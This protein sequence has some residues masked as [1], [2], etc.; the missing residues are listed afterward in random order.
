[1]SAALE[2][3]FVVSFIL[4]LVLNGVMSQLWNTFNTLQILLVMQL[5]AGLVMPSNVLVV[6]E[7]IDQVV[8]FS[9]LDSETIRK[10]FLAQLFEEPTETQ[11]EESSS[12]VTNYFKEASLLMQIFQILVSVIVLGL[13]ILLLVFCARKVLPKCCSC[14]QKIVM[15]I[16]A[17]LMFNSVLRALLQT[18]LLTSLSMW[19]SLK[20]MDVSTT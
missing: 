18:F 14:F 2:S 3:G 19:S 1:M 11:S 4:N 12:S 17:K 5:F 10:S 15:M 16:K 7:V 8:N 20:H 13:L 9:A 6:Q